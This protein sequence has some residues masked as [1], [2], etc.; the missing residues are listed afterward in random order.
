MRER[1]SPAP[2]PSNWAVRI[3]I[4]LDPEV[5]LVYPDKKKG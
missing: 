3:D 2:R 5:H 1:L 4:I